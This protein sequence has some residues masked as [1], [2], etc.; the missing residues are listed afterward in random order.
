MK[1]AQEVRDITK[2]VENKI[3][4]K[5][6]EKI[7]DKINLIYFCIEEAANNASYSVMFIAEPIEIVDILDSSKPEESGYLMTCNKYMPNV[8][9]TIKRNEMNIIKEYFRN[10]GYHVV[11]DDVAYKNILTI[12]WRL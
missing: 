2:D 1:T 12:D 7:M 11:F 10:M 5:L 3:F 9:I 4:N 8:K 6:C